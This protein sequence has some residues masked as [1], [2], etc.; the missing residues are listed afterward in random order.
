MEDH[1]AGPASPGLRRPPL[2]VVI[3]VRNGRNDFERCLRG[4][5]DSSRRDFEL[6]VIDDGSTDGSGK[7][8]EAHGARVVRHEVPRGPAASR[9]EGVELARSERIFFV[10][11]DVVV[12]GDAVAKVIERF[13]AE[14]DLAAFFGSYDDRPVARGV[15]SQFRNLLHHYV[16]Q[17]GE[18][19]A[20]ARPAHT[21]WTGCGAIRRGA[22]LAVG[23][24]DPRLYRRPAIED[25]ELGYRLTRS[26]HRVALVQDLQASHLKRWTLRSMV[27]TDVFQRGVPWMLLLLRSKT[28]ETDLNVSVAQRLSVAATGLACAGVLG[29]IA[30]PGSLVLAAVGLAA[31]FVLNARFYGF[32]TA[33]R[34]VGFAIASFWLHL[35]YFLCCGV[36]VPIALAMRLGQRVGRR[37][38]RERRRGERADRP[39]RARPKRLGRGVARRRLP[40]DLEH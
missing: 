10:D 29:A 39:S 32:L 9:N 23:G 5:R 35:V 21:F 34:G 33:K 13:E 38:V 6:I 7:L 25:I 14:P 4:L 12:H 11:A 3:P 17:Q 27:Y 31:V 20:E 36:S 16:H 26:G 37:A 8:A 28:R 1:P 24:F 22:F 15:V 30:A 19:V 2:S 40:S 18:F